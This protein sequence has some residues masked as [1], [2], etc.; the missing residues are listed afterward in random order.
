MNR[1]FSEQLL[2]ADIDPALLKQ[3]L[4]MG[5]A[6][7]HQ[8]RFSVYRNNVYSSLI[9][10]LG[11][12]FPVTRQI[13]G[14]EFFQAMAHAYIQRYPPT[15]PVLTEYGENF[16][17]FI[18]SRE[19][20]ATLPFLGEL[21]ALERA[22]LTLTH[23]LDYGVLDP[24][25]ASELLTQC[26]GE[27]AVYLT[28]SPTIML[29]RSDFAIGSIWLIHQ[30]NMLEKLKALVV[31]QR[32]CL[33]LYK[34]VLTAELAIISEPQ[35]QFIKSLLSGCD[36]QTAMKSTGESFDLSNTLAMLMN[37]PVITSVKEQ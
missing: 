32:E 12:I 37:C 5:H 1:W 27:K 35:G 20:L 25:S 26:D 2:A 30:Q 22:M 18:S 15:S 17:E 33:M 16:S 9:E 3:K 34:P 24:K 11:E 13:V 14:D 36:V 10:A 6:Q 19:P 29:F 7:E 28:L 31:E 8:Q 23:G 21:A 4:Q